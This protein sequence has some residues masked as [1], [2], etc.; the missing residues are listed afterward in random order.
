PSDASHGISQSIIPTGRVAIYDGDNFTLCA[1]ATGNLKWAKFPP[2]LDG[3][4]WTLLPGKDGKYTLRSR[5]G[6]YLSHCL[7]WGLVANRA[8]A[9]DWELLTLA[10]LG[11]SAGGAVNNDGAEVEAN[12]VACTIQTWRSSY[13]GVSLTT[14]AAAV[15]KATSLGPAA[16]LR[17][18]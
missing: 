2:A 10:P 9:S 12:H 1:D 18:V 13:L 11:R 4:I 3:N 15:E 14:P 17:I 8:A 7:M 5:H 16:V 6:K